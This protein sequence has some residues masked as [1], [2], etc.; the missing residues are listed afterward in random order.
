MPAVPQGTAAAQPG[1]RPGKQP[2]HP[3]GRRLQLGKEDSYGAAAEHYRPAAAVAAAAASGAAGGPVACGLD[4]G[5]TSGSCHQ[6]ATITT[7][8]GINAKASSSIASSSSCHLPSLQQQPACTLCPTGT[9][10]ARTEEHSGSGSPMSSG[11]SAG[12]DDSDLPAEGLDSLLYAP[13]GGSRGAADVLL[14]SAANRRLLPSSSSSSS[15]AVVNSNILALQQRLLL[16]QPG[17]DRFCG[18]ERAGGSSR[19]SMLAG[20]AAVA[21]GPS[22]GLQQAV[23]LRGPRMPGQQAASVPGSSLHARMASTAARA[24]LLLCRELTSLTPPPA[25]RMRPEAAV[26]QDTCAAAAAVTGASSQA[27]GCASMQPQ[28]LQPGE[29]ARGSSLR[30]VSV[31]RPSSAAKGKCSSSGTVPAGGPSS[32][33]AP[34]L[35]VAAA[36]LDQPGSILAGSTATS[37]SSGAG[38]S[39]AAGCAFSRRPL[40]AGVVC[41]GSSS[42]SEGGSSGRPSTS[43]SAS[44][45]GEPGM[46]QLHP[47]RT[48]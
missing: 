44:S 3:A 12:A 26:P 23:Q 43:G 10:V 5:S 30:F 7:P 17:A 22:A 28:Q 47:Q 25:P 14:P 15:K 2:Q 34:S 40:S 38:D 35:Q 42:G 19:S 9:V 24:Q 29:L 6:Q 32:L 20:Q 8:P 39:T 16:P 21:A 48:S 11:Q 36:G 37:T 45:P 46:T 1:S 33:V 27:A 13:W 4:E 18:S 31:S 41:W